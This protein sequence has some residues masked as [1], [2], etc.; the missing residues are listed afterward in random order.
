MQRPGFRVP[1]EASKKEIIKSL[2]TELANLQMAGRI[3]QM[4]TQELMKSVKQMANDLGG[5]FNQL[6]ELQYS[7]DALVKQLGVDKEV[8][9]KIANEA[10][11]VDF[12]K[13][14]DKQDTDDSLVNADAVGA[15]STVTITS[16]AKDEEGTDKGIFRSRLKLSECGSPDLINSLAGKKVGDRVAVKLNDIEH[17][18]ELLAI[19][20]PAPEQE[21]QAPASH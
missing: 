17:L 19:R 4:M 11:L 21:A 3:S 10:R 13:A 6:Y 1:A 18:V 9:T 5:A 2:Q 14:S 16:V 7:Y 8:L 12:N 15:D 20:N